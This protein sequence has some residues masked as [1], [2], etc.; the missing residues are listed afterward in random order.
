MNINNIINDIE[1]NTDFGLFY[2]DENNFEDPEIFFGDECELGVVFYSNELKID[3]FM[4]F[5]YYDYPTSI[6]NEL[7]DE[8]IE[9]ESRTWLEENCF[10]IFL[11]ENFNDISV[12]KW[13]DSSCMCPGYVSKVGLSKI[14]YNINTIIKF[15]QIITNFYSKFKNLNDTDL[16]LYICNKIC[17]KFNLDFENIDYT[18]L[19]FKFNLTST[20]IGYSNILPEYYIG[21]DYSLFY[22]NDEMYY[23]NSKPFKLFFEINMAI[24]LNNSFL[25]YKSR[26]NIHI[27]FDYIEFIF[28]P[29]RNDFFYKI[30][31]NNLVN[32]IIKFLPFSTS[33]FKGRFSNIHELLYNS[34]KSDIIVFTEGKTDLIHLKK[35]WDY[36]RDEFEF[37]NLNLDFY[38]ENNARK[39]HNYIMGNNELLNMCKYLSKVK[40]DKIMIFI[41]DSDDEKFTKEFSSSNGIKNWGNNVYSFVL[42]KPLYRSDYN[43]IC[44][45]YLYTDD[46]MKTLYKC[47]DGILRRIFVGNEFDIYGRHT[48][49]KL[50]CTN[51][52]LCGPNSK[53]IIDGSNKEKV[54]NCFY[55]DNTNYALSKYDFAQY[56]VVNIKS[57]SYQ[58]FKSI[59]KLIAKIAR[60]DI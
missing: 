58:S 43:G 4:S 28:L 8:E 29:M 48:S 56:S 46:E 37:N 27:V 23:I 6:Y 44:I 53:K 59:F 52:N 30:E 36:I 22:I 25:L 26:N 42:P 45:E 39:H 57:E 20:K 54:I 16:R 7:S 49:E 51:R 11:K 19:D 14:P 38:E 3:I 10:M 40:N 24:N 1:K 2:Y 21:K 5:S 32:E 17:K 47:K 9:F 50:L 41:A 31:Q 33:K 55:S 60:N 13:D 18:N 15:S 34:Y 35:F 12:S